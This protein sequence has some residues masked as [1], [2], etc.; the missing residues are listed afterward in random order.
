M[1]I[2]ISEILIEAIN[3]YYTDLL[4]ISKRKKYLMLNK[5]ELDNL[6]EAVS[7]YYDKV[8]VLGLLNEYT[9]E[10]KV[11]LENL[12]FLKESLS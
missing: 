5:E 6:I 12:K 7:S 3:D 10:V 8:K 11:E 9:D 1:K 2:R 4:P